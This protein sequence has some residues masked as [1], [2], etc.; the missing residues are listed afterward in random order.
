MAFETLI[1][2]TV[3]LS[4]A[5]GGLVVHVHEPRIVQRD[6]VQLLLSSRRHVTQSLLR[7]RQISTTCKELSE[8]TGSAE[9]S[10]QGSGGGTKLADEVR[11]E[12]AAQA[13][14]SAVRSLGIGRLQRQ[15][16]AA[17]KFF[18]WYSIAALRL[19]ASMSAVSLSTNE[20]PTERTWGEGKS[21]G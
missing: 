20:L 3:E 19:K 13:L 15:A 21:E 6:G 4:E 10:N 8:R 17:S 7:R 11:E 12:G 16:W 5:S 2:G 9:A 1:A 18:I 14:A